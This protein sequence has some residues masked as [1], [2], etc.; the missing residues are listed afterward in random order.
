MSHDQQPFVEKLQ[1]FCTLATTEN[2]DHLYTLASARALFTS[3]A[4]DAAESAFVIAAVIEHLP[5]IA[6]TNSK[7]GDDLVHELFKAKASTQALLEL[8]PDMAEV[9]GYVARGITDRLL[10]REGIEPHVG[11][12]CSAFALRPPLP[13]TQS[14]VLITHSHSGNWVTSTYNGLANLPEDAVVSL[15][16]NI[17]NAP[18]FSAAVTQYKTEAAHSCS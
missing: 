9:N 15:L 11:F 2:Q 12:T 10:L 14:T 7:V 1:E 13:G 6:K 4:D 3:S 17:A 5:T 18:T 8:L 16:P